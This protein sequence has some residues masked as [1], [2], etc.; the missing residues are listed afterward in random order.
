M[1]EFSA[2]LQTDVRP[3]LVVD[4][5]RGEKLRINFDMTFPKMACACAH[6]TPS[7]PKTAFRR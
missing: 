4:T 7:H 2:F 6:P 5:S 1:S 3:E